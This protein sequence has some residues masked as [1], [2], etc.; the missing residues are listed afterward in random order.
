MTD[1]RSWLRD[2]LDWLRTGLVLDPRGRD[3]IVLAYILPPVAAGADIGS[4]AVPSGLD[5]TTKTLCPG[6]AYDRSPCGTGTSAKLAAM[7]AR[8]ADS[9]ASCCSWHSAHAV[10]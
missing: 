3:A 6:T 2:N 5:A 10:I 4:R 9:S 7:H 8:T 1:K